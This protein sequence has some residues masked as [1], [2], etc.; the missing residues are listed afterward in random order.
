M[1]IEKS[2]EDLLIFKSVYSKDTERKINEE[3]PHI[4]GIINL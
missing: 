2:V 3:F 4:Q 1:E